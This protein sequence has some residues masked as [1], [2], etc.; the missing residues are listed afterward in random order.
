MSALK[1]INRNWQV[2]LIGRSDLPDGTEVEI[3]PAG[4]ISGD[5]DMPGP[6]TPDEIAKTLAAMDQVEP[7]EMTEAERA[8]IE[9]NRQ[10]RKEWEKVHFDEHN[11]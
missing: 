1:G 9:A 3:V 2:I 7:F 10:A 5:E 4:L 11:D 6:M 8:A